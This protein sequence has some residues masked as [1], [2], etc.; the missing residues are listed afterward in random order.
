MLEVQNSKQKFRS[1]SHRF[2]EAVM[3]QTYSLT[4]YMACTSLRNKAQR[5][6][7]LAPS[8]PSAFELL[9]VC[10]LCVYSLLLR[11]SQGLLIGLILCQKTFPGTD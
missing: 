7:R 3:R 8:R 1:Q 4:D 5:L 2:T 9:Q 11:L 6:K 10:G